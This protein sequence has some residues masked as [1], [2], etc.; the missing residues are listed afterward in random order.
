M[1]FAV[2]LTVCGLALFVIMVVFGQARFSNDA[3]GYNAVFK[4]CFGSPRRQPGSG[5]RVEV[6]KVQRITVNDD[7]TVRWNSPLILP[8]SSPGTRAEVRYDDLIGRFLALADGAG[9][10]KCSNPGRPSRWSGHVW[11]SIWIPSPVDS[12][13]CFGA[14]TGPGRDLSGQLMKAFPGRGTD[15]RVVPRPGSAGE[16]HLAERDVLIGQV[17][18][19]LN[20]LLGTWVGRV[21][22]STRR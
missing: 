2:F 9:G 6:G 14:A 13:R 18:D 12:A 8:R 21:D 10:S 3:K 15:H 16:Q 11:R 5:G 4:G 22:N 1:R 17:V 19:N 20:V 7:A